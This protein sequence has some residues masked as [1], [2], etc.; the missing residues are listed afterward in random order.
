MSHTSWTVSMC[1]SCAT[2]SGVLSG[3]PKCVQNQL[4]VMGSLLENCRA[5]LR[6]ME[7]AK[8]SLLLVGEQHKTYFCLMG[9]GMCCIVSARNFKSSKL[10][11]KN[12]SSSILDKETKTSMRLESGASGKWNAKSSIWSAVGFKP[13]CVID[14]MSDLS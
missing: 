8:G 14:S 4:K 13:T 10:H 6:N 9:I 1:A 5:T 12:L 11:M 2:V 3:H 7:Q